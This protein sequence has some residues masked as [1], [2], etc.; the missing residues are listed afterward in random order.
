MALLTREQFASQVFERDRLI[1]VV[2]G[3]DKEAIDAHHIMERRL[4]CDGDPLPGGY[5]KDNG[6]SLCEIHHIHAEEGY[7]PP[8][9]LRDWIGIDKIILPIIC[10]KDCFY[11]KWGNEIAK[12]PS[13]QIKY[14]KTPYLNISPSY[15]NDDEIIDTKSLVGKPLSVTIKRDGSCVMMTSE[16]CAARNGSDA[17]HPSFNLLKQRHATLKYKIPKGVQ[18]FGEWLF[19]K[20]SIHYAGQLALRDYLEI[21][22]VYDQKQ[23]LFY[24][25]DDMQI[26]CDDL[27]L[28]MV[29]RLAIL[30]H[31]KEWELTNDIVG[32]AEEVIAKGE[33]GI[34]IK[35]M[36]PFHY[37]QFSM[38]TAKY[39]RSDFVPGNAHWSK[40]IT[41][42]SIKV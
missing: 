15:D 17:S 13:Y 20:H 24:S 42:N 12:A 29:T 38:N 19:A 23:Q 7:F 8:Q 14:P 35:S 32:L 16:I 22:A 9:A 28:I 6:A 37:S 25:Q 31:T 39:V 41:K 18:I 30:S 10:K 27:D 34:V 2:P 33:E 40:Q 1:C 21:F 36:Y 4:F 3:C 5:D 26:L 11:D